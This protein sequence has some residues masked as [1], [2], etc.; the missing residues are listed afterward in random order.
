MPP[1]ERVGDVLVSN[2]IQSFDE[3]PQGALIGTGSM[4][5]KAQLLNQRPDL[6]VEDIRGNVDTRLQKLDGG[7]YEAIIL[8]ES[9]LKRLGLVER[10]T[11][12]IDRSVMIPAVGQGALGIECREDDAYVRQ[13]LANLNDTETF[14]TVTAER[15]M[16]RSLRAGCLA[17][18]GAFGQISEGKL[19]LQGVVL[20]G[21]GDQR[22][23]AKA[24]VAL[25]ELS[26]L[27][28]VD[29]ANTLGQ[30]IAKDLISQGAT[31]LISEARDNA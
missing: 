12:V 4:R 11:H 31:E 28:Q 7:N 13:V 8:A 1:R 30:T 10:I 23:D 5:R 20:S 3:I 16:L 26:E 15:A 29:T 21:T 17:P 14:V 24:E 25:A 18:V 6:R 19:Q 2:T 27:E 22:V 9:G